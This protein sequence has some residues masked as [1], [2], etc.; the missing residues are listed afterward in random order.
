MKVKYEYLNETETSYIVSWYAKQEVNDTILAIINKNPIY[1]SR[2]ITLCKDPVKK[3]YSLAVL[4][5]NSNKSLFSKQ[6]A[7]EVLNLQQLILFLEQVKKVRGFGR[8][9]R[10][11]VISFFHRRGID[12]LQKDFASNIGNTAWTNRDILNKFHVKP[13]SSDVSGLFKFIVEEGKNGRK[14]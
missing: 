4:S 14:A 7:W 8:T 5:L 3:M 11:A 12:N 2:S 1:F 6:F 13:W 9:V 10:E